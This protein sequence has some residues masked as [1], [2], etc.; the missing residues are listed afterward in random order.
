MKP[1]ARLINTARGRIINEDDLVTTLKKGEITA[2]LD[3]THLKAT[4]IRKHFPNITRQCRDLGLD[5]TK[6]PIPVVPAAHYMCGGIKVNLDGS[7]LPV[8]RHRL[9]REAINP[10]LETS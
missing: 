4:Y 3:V 2:Y 7:R 8:N 5:I 10:Q 1:G 9:R 6:E